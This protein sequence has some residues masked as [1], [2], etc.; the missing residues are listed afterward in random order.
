[1]A[2]E[3][4]KS[5]LPVMKRALFIVLAVFLSLAV[6]EVLLRT[7]GYLYLQ[8]LYPSKSHHAKGGEFKILC[9]GD[10]FTQG[11]GA[12]AGLS[13]PEQLELMLNKEPVHQK[14]KAYKTFYINSST[15]L[16]NL[17]DDI[18]HYEPDL[19]I[20]M[21]GCND[22]WSMENCTYR[23]F[24]K[25]S[26]LKKADIWLSNL[27]VYKM[28]KILVRNAQTVL[29]NV[30]PWFGEKSAE[31]GAEVKPFRY[32]IADPAA[33]TLFFKGEDFFGAGQYDRAL[34]EWQSALERE[35]HNV[36]IH[37][38]L[39]CTYFQVLGERDL[40][41]KHALLALA[42]GDKSVV[43]HVFM[44]LY[45]PHEIKSPSNMS[46]VARMENVISSHYQGEDRNEA[47]RIVKLLCL[48]AEETSEVEGML[49]YN[50]DRIMEIAGS[51][52]VKVLL[53]EYPVFIF[54]IHDVI[55]RKAHAHKVPLIDNFSIF[56]ALIKEGSSRREDIFAKDGHCNAAGYG[57]VAKNIY[58]TMAQQSIVREIGDIK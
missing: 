8:V 54:Q 19:I 30:T 12:P 39:A 46:L 29:G 51:R 27:N 24:K 25:W 43:G 45:N 31:A 34:Q 26:A 21:T 22:R 56:D 35:P 2:A 10:S 23:Q 50:L 47:L 48:F 49:G 44:L 32:S 36:S 3:T 9:L 4:S 20:L 41:I 1:M 37:F 55:R 7:S 28:V 53:M 13:Y 58:N 11:L 42:Y 38:R 18:R 5:T 6:F 52:N 16:K 57:L 15:V 14:V 40:G 17:N 33:N